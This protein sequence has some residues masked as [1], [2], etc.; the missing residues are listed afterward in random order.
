MH[1]LYLAQETRDER[2]QRRYHVSLMS[3]SK[4]M[5]ILH[6]FDVESLAMKK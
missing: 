5:G 2:V 1:R 4:D 3:F 6:V